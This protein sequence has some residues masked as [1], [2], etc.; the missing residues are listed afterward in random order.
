MVYRYI[1]EC[2]RGGPLTPVSKV[3]VFSLVVFLGVTMRKFLANDT[4]LLQAGRFR[5]VSTSRGEIASL[6]G[7]IIVPPKVNGR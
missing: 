6:A 5:R 2:C 1:V 3:Q 4:N 7:Y